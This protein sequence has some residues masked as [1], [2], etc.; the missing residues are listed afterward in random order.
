MF[1]YFAGQKNNPDNIS[2]AY[3]PDH[4]KDYAPRMLKLIDCYNGD[5]LYRVHERYIIFRYK[6]MKAVIFK[7]CY[8]AVY[9][10]NL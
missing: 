4:L 10:E 9:K 7:Q 5:F 3:S 1:S 2:A 8:W 6:T